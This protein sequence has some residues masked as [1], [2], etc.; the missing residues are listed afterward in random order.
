MKIQAQVSIC[1]LRT[2][3]LSGPI[4]EF[5]RILKEK[6]LKVQMRTM[7]SLIMGQLDIVF[8]ALQQAF[9]QIAEKYNVVMD[10]KISN[11]CPEETEKEAKKEQI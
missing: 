4:G 6:G 9:G 7:D 10:C 5:C 3:S 2:E 11:A 8:E 1:P